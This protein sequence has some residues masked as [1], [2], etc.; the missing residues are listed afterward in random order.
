MWRFHWE[1]KVELTLNKKQEQHFSFMKV[2]IVAVCH[3]IILFHAKCVLD[4]FH[5]W[6]ALVLFNL[7]IV[8]YQLAVN[9]RGSHNKHSN[10]GLMLETFWNSLRR[11]INIINSV[12]KPNYLVKLHH[13]CSITVFSKKLTPFRSVA[14]LPSIWEY[15][16]LHYLM[17][18]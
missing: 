9:G 4:L 2:W 12:N 3:V 11:P 14:I 16:T 15:L 8:S 1:Q 7:H 18:L 6:Q 13:W 5:Y 17:Y 10:K